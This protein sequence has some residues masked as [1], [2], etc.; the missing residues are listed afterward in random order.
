MNPL[1]DCCGEGG[2]RAADQA[3]DLAMDP[4]SSLH[5]QC[6]HELWVATGRTRLQPQAAEMRETLKGARTQWR[7]YI[8]EFLS[9]LMV[10]YV[11]M[12]GVDDKAE[13][14]WRSFFWHKQREF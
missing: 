12:E 7:G 9:D 6:V 1:L 13:I 5:L 10:K 8:G 4:R 14:L 11:Y 3:L 2:A